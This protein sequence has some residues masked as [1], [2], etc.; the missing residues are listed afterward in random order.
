VDSHSPL[1]LAYPLNAPK[2]SV[3]IPTYNRS[4]LILAAVESVLSQTYTDYELIVI[5]DGSTDSTRERLRPYLDR[6]RYFYQPNRGVSA[7]RNAGV[8]AARGEWL[9]MLD[10][11]DVWHPTKL[12]RQLDALAALGDGFGACFTDCNYIGNPAISSTVF[13][14]AG[15][16]ADVP[17]GP[18]DNPLHYMVGNRYGICIPSLLVLRSLVN[19]IGGFDETLGLAED[20][21]LIFKLT[22]KTKFCFISTPLVSI[23]RRPE[24]SRL[25]DL[26]SKRVGQTYIWG[27]LLLKKML[28]RPELVDPEIRQMLQEELVGFYYNWAAASLNDLKLSSFLENIQKIRD[29]GQSYRKIFW[30]LLSRAARKLSRR[31]CLPFDE[32]GA[33]H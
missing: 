11:D 15:F 18:L 13:E 33:L 12:E 6:I 24:V 29:M 20:R 26:C 17:F 32:P 21:D 31:L 7:A 23:D 8:K 30:T 9:S 5:D 16:N 2:V 22:F 27:E 28:A 19:E 10:S 25:T 1:S 14:A 4:E 3:V